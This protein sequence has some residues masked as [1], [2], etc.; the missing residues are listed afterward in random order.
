MTLTPGRSTFPS[1]SPRLHAPAPRKAA[2]Q[3]GGEQEGEAE[4]IETPSWILVKPGEDDKEEAREE[5][6][7]GLYGRGVGMG[8]KSPVKRLR[9]AL[10]DEVRWSK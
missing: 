5:L 6:A 7:L 4:R 2:S 10:G 9:R 8:P 3:Y 1:L